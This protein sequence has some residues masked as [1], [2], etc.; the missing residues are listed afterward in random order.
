MLKKIYV[1]YTH[2]TPSMG[3]DLIA[4]HSCHYTSIHLSYDYLFCNIY[5][6]IYVC[7]DDFDSHYEGYGNMQEGFCN[8]HSLDACKQFGEAR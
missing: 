8:V 4:C 7:P 5:D 2:R 1:L 6:N 3:Y